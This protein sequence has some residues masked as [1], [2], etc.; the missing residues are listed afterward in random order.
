MPTDRR[1]QP[2]SNTGGSGDEE[3]HPIL[4]DHGYRVVKMLGR[5][6]YANVKLAYSDRHQ[7]HVAVKVIQK[8]DAPA[9]YLDKFLPREIAIVKMLKHPHLIVF[10]QASRCR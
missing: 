2:A 5:G 7:A 9:E 8:R 1:P 10:L 6:S 3:R 4:E